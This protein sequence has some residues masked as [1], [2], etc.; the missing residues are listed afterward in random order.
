MRLD[1]RDFDALVNLGLRLGKR[2]RA[3][4]ARACLDRSVREAPPS[5][6]AA[7]I[8]RATVAGRGG[9][10]RRAYPAVTSRGNAG[11]GTAGARRSPT[12][13]RHIA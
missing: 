7:E 5:F 8:Q 6:Y 11:A 12:C 4:E 3:P 10:E 13:C 9:P 2:G 1:P